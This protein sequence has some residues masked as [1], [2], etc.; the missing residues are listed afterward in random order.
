MK[1][2]YN[3]YINKSNLINIRSKLI[4]SWK[5]I[6]LI[7]RWILS[8]ILPPLIFAIAAFTVVSVSVGVIFELI[9]KIV[10]AGL[11]FQIAFH[12]LLLKLPS[13]LVISFPMAMLMSSL[14][15]YSRL[16]SNSELKAL[17]SL[18]VTTSRMI[19]PA[20]ALSLFMTGLTFVFNDSIV[21]VSNRNAEITLKSALG[22][23]LATEKGNDII[24]SKFGLVTDEKTQVTRD[25]L[26]HLFYSRRFRNG[27]MQEVTVV[28]FS[29]FGHT[30]LLVAKRAVWNDIK[31]RWEFI[32][33][34]TINLAPN[35]SS[36]S[37]S[38]DRYF[39]PLGNGPSKIAK[40]PKDANDM[41]VAETLQAQ[42]LYS[43]VGNV[44]EVR[45]MQVRVQEKF[46]LPMACVVFGLIGSSL[47]AKPDTSTSRSQGFGL[48]VVLILSYYILSFGFSALGVK[49]TLPPSLAAWSPVFISLSV[50]GLLL[51]RASR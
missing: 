47:G 28:D 50:G 34:K 39:Y 49:G 32:D 46:T 33:G 20:L 35:G 41:T 37:S 31:S 21:P 45:R 4:S 11:P 24:Y 5:V 1:N 13:F 26:T 22:K 6:P 2:L 38:F 15:A 25:G 18:G 16:S 23:S 40:L 10:E 14:I 27:E 19:A 36:T 48:S 43:D 44:K 30:Q 42:K 12:V 17:R 8:E 29:R 51:K 7:D 3:P 9:R